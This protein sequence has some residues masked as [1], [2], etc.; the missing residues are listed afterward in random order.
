MTAKSLQLRGI[1]KRFATEAVLDE[2]TLELRPG[3]HVCV[4]GSSGAGKSPWPAQ[5]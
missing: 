4:M 3:T 2:V 1:S 5:P